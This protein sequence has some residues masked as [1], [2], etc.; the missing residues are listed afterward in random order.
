MLYL[1][2]PYQREIDAEK[3][4]AIV[5]VNDSIPSSMDAYEPWKGG[6]GYTDMTPTA[7]EH[8]WKVIGEIDGWD[9]PTGYIPERELTIYF[10]KDPSVTWKLYRRAA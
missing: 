1:F 6:I 5:Q 2:Q 3:K 9:I 4:L 8:G 7:I 10:G